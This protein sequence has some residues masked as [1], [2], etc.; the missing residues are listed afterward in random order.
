MAELEG[1]LRQAAV[2]G[3]TKSKDPQT[4]SLRRN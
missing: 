2:T 4:L 3:Q 1:E